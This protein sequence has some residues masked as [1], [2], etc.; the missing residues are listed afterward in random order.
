L[1]FLFFWVGKGEREKRGFVW[2]GKW[3]FHLSWHL[4]DTKPQPS[5]WYNPAF[6]E[7]KISGT[8]NDCLLSLFF[9]CLTHTHGG[10]FK[11][12]TKLS[13]NSP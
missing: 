4:P 10:D 13:K 8:G 12:F 7:E 2:A 1:L 6:V 5:P 3:F 11:V 9:F